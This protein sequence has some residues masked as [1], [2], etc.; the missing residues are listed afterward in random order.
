MYV[1]IR[2]VV[3]DQSSE[4]PLN[5]DDP[6]LWNRRDIAL[7]LLWIELGSDPRQKPLR[8]AKSGDELL[9]PSYTCKWSQHDSLQNSVKA[10]DTTWP[11]GAC[12]VRLQS[13]LST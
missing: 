11:K 2:G 1:H 3:K 6:S 5:T 13:M 8:S 9:V 7:P 12:M 10:M 4:K